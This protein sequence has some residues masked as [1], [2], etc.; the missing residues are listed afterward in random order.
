[1]DVA[2]PATARRGT[3][4]AALHALPEAVLAVGAAVL[5]LACAQLVAPGPGSAVMAVVLCLSLARSRLE[6]DRR[7]RIEAAVALPVVALAA[8]GVGLLLRDAPWLGAAAFTGSLAL[9]VWLRQFG[10]A[11]R[12]AARLIALP[13]VAVLTLPHLAGVHRG[14]L[15]APLLPVF[16]ALLA[17]AWVSLLDALGRRLGLLADPF[18]PTGHA[19]PGA[20]AATAATAARFSP[21]TRMAVQMGVALAGAFAAGHAF[22]G[23][24]WPWVVLTAFIVHSGNRGRL[25]VAYTSVLRTVGAAAGTLAAVLLAVPPGA[26]AGAVAALVLSAVF[27]GT[28]LRPLNYAW[29]ALF[30]TLALAL[31]QGYAG[32]PSGPAMLERL[33]AIATGAAIGVAVAWWV[34]PVRSTDVLRR[35]L[36]TALACL[37]DA[38][39][40]ASDQRTPACFGHALGQL[41]Q[42]AP[43]FRAASLLPHRRMRAP[44]QWIDT[45]LDCRA[46]ALML[47]AG[48]VSPPAVRRAI[49][50]ARQALREPARLQPA[51]EA[52]REALQHTSA[53]PAPA[54]A[55][56]PLQ[57]A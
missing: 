3:F 39:D 9:S 18:P 12:R 15:P 25:D 1:M 49:G 31:L 8:T 28:W 24:H 42:L 10:E 52:L 21:T 51:L 56:A 11:A 34:L 40:P 50:A 6:R 38:L 5:T 20:T 17:L 48:G 57:D 43:A 46:Q 29:W 33:A 45:L 22:F 47:I 4:A 26:H 35:R 7:G 55:P 53:T 44:A 27:L 41:E 32:L 16:I 37:A 36:A 14:P 54:S 2:L 30:A 23:R 19:A 13:L